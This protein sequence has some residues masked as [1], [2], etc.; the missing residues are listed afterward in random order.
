M[1]SCKMLWKG[2]LLFPGCVCPGCLC[3]RVSLSLMFLSL[4]YLG[5]WFSGGCSSAWFTVG[6]DD[7]KGVFQPQWFYD[8]TCMGSDRQTSAMVL[9]TREEFCYYSEG[10][11]RPGGVRPEE[12]TKIIRGMENMSC[13]ERLWDGDCL[14]W[15]RQGSREPLE[16]SQVPK[17]SL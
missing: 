9:W 17:G 14:A 5:T 1:L 3:S 15:K 10:R 13:K 12:A 2:S 16:H 11:Q 4:R 7:L 8:S 6:I